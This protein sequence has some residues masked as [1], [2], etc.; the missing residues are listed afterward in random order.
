V[1]ITAETGAGSRHYSNFALYAVGTGIFYNLRNF[2]EYA[3]LILKT[4][5]AEA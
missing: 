5:L 1:Q 3:A 2:S 4:C